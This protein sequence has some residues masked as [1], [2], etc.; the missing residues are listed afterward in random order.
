MR[1][2]CARSPQR[3][4]ALRRRQTFIEHTP[5]PAPSPSKPASAP[6][7]CSSPWRRSQRQPSWQRVSPARGHSGKWQRC[8]VVAVSSGRQPCCRQRAA[9]RAGDAGG[10]GRQRQVGTQ[11]PADSK[12]HAAQRQPTR[13]YPAAWPAPIAPGP[14]CTQFQ[15]SS[16]THTQ[17]WPRL[18]A[19]PVAIAVLPVPG[20][21]ASSTPRPAILPSLTICAITPAACAAHR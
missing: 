4:P 14:E 13:Q 2:R 21:P 3:P 12:Q 19:M 1:P 8:R 18:L 9:E 11:P 17:T 5:A 10:G 20:W 16:S 7:S 15:R 6:P